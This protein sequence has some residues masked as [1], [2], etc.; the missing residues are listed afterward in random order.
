MIRR[1]CDC[2]GVE[3]VARNSFRPDNVSELGRLKATLKRGKSSLTVEV[4][5]SKDG[6][7][8]SGDFCAHCV[9]D[10]LTSVDDRPRAG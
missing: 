6:V 4:I 1:F 5:T 7:S 10:A 2:C 3:I 8:N 9:L